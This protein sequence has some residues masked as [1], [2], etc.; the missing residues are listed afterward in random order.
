M[1][2]CMAWL[3]AV[4][5]SLSLCACGQSV[6]SEE[7]APSADSGKA[8]PD[9]QTAER[10]KNDEDVEQDDTKALEWFAKAVEAGSLEDMT[11]IGVMYYYGYGVEKNYAKAKEWID[12][13]ED[14]GYVS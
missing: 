4:A 14:A 5:L 3:L 11:I 9:A 13:A 6:K 12:K 2:K 7:P 8:L 10:Y 1:K